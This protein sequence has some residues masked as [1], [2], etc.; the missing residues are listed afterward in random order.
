MYVHDLV[1]CGESEE[2]L[3][4]MVRCFIKVCRRRGVKVNAHKRNMM[5]LEGERDWIGMRGVF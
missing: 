3:K 5:T 2:N 1:L 4:M